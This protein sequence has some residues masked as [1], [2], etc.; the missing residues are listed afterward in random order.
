M[1]DSDIYETL[2]DVLRETFDNDELVATAQTTAAQVPGWDSLGNVR[3]FVAVEEAF[4]MRFSAAE[5]NGL[6][7]LGAV[8]DLIARRQSK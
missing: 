7:N 3:F 5:M 6:S 1:S 8:V 2:T 4:G